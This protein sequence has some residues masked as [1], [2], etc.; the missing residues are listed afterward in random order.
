MK[1]R[2]VSIFAFVLTI[3]S[4]GPVRHEDRMCQID[5]L[6]SDET[7]ATA[8]KVAYFPE[9]FAEEMRPDQCGT[10]RPRLGEV[11]RE[12]YPKHWRAACEK[13]LQDAEQTGGD[14]QFV[15]RFSLLPSFDNPLIFRLETREHGHR[16]IVKQLTGHGG[17]EPGIISRSKELELSEDE[18]K[19][20][21]DKLRM[22]RGS[23][24]AAMAQ[25]EKEGPKDTCFF[26]FDGTEW[27]LE[28]VEHGQYDIFKATSPTEGELHEVGMMLLEKS[29]WVEL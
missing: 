5:K 2:L 4:C 3:S 11:E 13:P 8:N 23:R 10:E 12:W 29:G 20:I 15:F 22:M 27:I 1:L 18:I 6:S 16:L 24:A 7:E 28:V 19:I 21:R 26:T 14:D 9:G 17:Y 25:F